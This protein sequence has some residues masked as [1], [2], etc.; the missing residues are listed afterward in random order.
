M[1]VFIHP[2][3]RDSLVSLGNFYFVGIR[4]AA[5][6]H[7]PVSLA[8]LWSAVRTSPRCAPVASSVV[9]SVFVYCCPEL[10]CVANTFCPLLV[11]TISSPFSRAKGSYVREGKCSVCSMCRVQFA[12]FRSFC[13]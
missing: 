13:L 10:V 2:Q 9:L 8:S 12:V 4:F 7:I 6:H 5:G 1:Y 11:D 3:M